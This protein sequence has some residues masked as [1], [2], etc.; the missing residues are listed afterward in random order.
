[1]AE[2][3]T[4]AETALLQV[5]VQAGKRSDEIVTLFAEKGIERTYKSVTRKLE[6]ERAKD[7]ADW[8]AMVAL[9]TTKRWDTQLRVTADRTLI[10]PDIHAPFHDADWINRCIGLALRMGCDTVALPGD[11]V[12]F[13]A[14]SKFGRQERVEAEDE[15]LAAR[16]IV[17]ALAH[18]FARV[19]YTGGNHEMRLPRKTD[20]LLELRDAMEMFVNAPNVQV[21]DYHWFELVSGGEMFHVEHPKP[22]SSTAI[23]VPRALCRKFLCHIIGTHGHM[24][25]MGR[26][27]S[28]RFW[29][30]DSGVACDPLRL[31]YIQKVHSTRPMVYQGA[32]LV[33]DGVPLL[34]S[35]DNIATFEWLA[36]PRAA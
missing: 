30:V 6:R 31:A 29:L 8:H 36:T 9:A 34:L 20:N 21:S 3:W 22:S 32:C 35:P 10:L 12:D 17:T 16:Q 11:L 19:I 27:E 28:G 24:W 14:F 4:N 18:S 25:G 1:M 5:W 23:V 26:D 33:L 2:T 15:I 13:A 7:P